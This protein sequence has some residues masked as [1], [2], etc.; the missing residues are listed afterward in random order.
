MIATLTPMRAARRAPF[1]ERTISV[2]LPGAAWAAIL[3]TLEGREFSQKGRDVAK[4]ATKALGE[5]LL[6]HARLK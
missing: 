1:S 3:G 5:Q 6:I 4:A 2:T